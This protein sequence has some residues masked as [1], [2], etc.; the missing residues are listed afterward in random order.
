MDQTRGSF[1]DRNFRVVHR[2]HSACSTKGSCRH[3]SCPA[4]CLPLRLLYFHQYPVF[5]PSF[6]HHHLPSAVHPKR[7]SAMLHLH[8]VTSARLQSLSTPEWRRCSPAL[9]CRLRPVSRNS[10]SCCTSKLYLLLQACLDPLRSTSMLRQTAC[11]LST[12]HR[13]LVRIRL[14]LMRF[15]GLHHSCPLRCM[16]TRHNRLKLLSPTLDVLKSN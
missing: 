8:R 4:S 16:T 15:T 3:L 7:H 5:H 11:I 12:R 6:L 13:E 14:P 1:L 10:P 2:C 9:R